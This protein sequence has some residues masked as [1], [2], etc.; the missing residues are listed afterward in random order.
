MSECKHGSVLCETCRRELQ[1]TI[2][3]FYKACELASGLLGISMDEESLLLNSKQA[4]YILRAALK[5]AGKT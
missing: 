2:D 3:Q 1:N 4:Q 5:K